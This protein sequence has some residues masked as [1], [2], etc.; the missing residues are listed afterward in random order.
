MLAHGVPWQAALVMQLEMSIVYI[1]MLLI[2]LLLG[3][4]G[5]LP[6]LG[7]LMLIF[8]FVILIGMIPLFMNLSRGYFTLLL[9]YLAGHI[10]VTLLAYALQY[11]H[12]GIVASDN[13][14]INNFQDSLYFSVTTWTTLGYGD[15]VPIQKMRLATSLEVLTG[16]ISM[17]ITVSFI[18]LWCTEN[19]VPKEMAFFDGKRRYKK[20]LSIHRMRIRTLTGKPR[21]LGP[22]WV[23]PPK[24]GESYT[25][26]PE[27][28]EWVVVTE[29]MAL[30]EGAKI[31]EKDDRTSD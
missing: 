14:V 23:D 16:F 21:D 10:I 17:A 25:W 18:W 20:S 11:W 6:L 3:A 5:W 29:D 4:F 22:D 24:P 1:A 12:A 13:S 31:L 19:L 15:F 30:N 27:K 2:S 28:E 8:A 7:G 26:S 9:G